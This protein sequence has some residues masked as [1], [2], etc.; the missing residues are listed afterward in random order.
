[1][2]LQEHVPIPFLQ[3]SNLLGFYKYSHIHK[4]RNNKIYVKVKNTQ[5]FTF[6][7][8]TSIASPCTEE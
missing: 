6:F 5:G 1:M 4:L 3:T 2:G 7:A 8:A